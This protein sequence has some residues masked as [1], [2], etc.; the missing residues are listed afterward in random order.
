MEFYEWFQIVGAVIFGNLLF[1]LAAYAWWRV[2]KNMKEGRQPYDL[3]VGVCVCGA[4]APLVA[5]FSLY[6]T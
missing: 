5:F 4:V 6:W 3:P 2:D 1:G